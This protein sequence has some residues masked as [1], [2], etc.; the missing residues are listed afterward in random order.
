MKRSIVFVVRDPNQV[1][2]VFAAH[3]PMSEP[4]LYV[5][6]SPFSL[7]IGLLGTN[8][9]HVER[10]AEEF[11]A[12]CAPQ[13]V[14]MTKVNSAQYEFSTDQGTLVAAGSLRDGVVV[15]LRQMESPALELQLLEALATKCDRF[16][17]AVQFPTGG[18]RSTPITL[19]EALEKLKAAA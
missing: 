4:K 15:T 9:V 8:H 14:K 6:G 10:Y 5:G 2:T 13:S 11:A 18:G 16:K 3:P 1:A 12:G 7:F 19:A 17:S